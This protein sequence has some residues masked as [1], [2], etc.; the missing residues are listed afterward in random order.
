MFWVMG[1]VTK[2]NA[3]VFL[4]NIGKDVN[5]FLQSMFHKFALFLKN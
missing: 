3:I 4:L 5:I 1:E 2:A